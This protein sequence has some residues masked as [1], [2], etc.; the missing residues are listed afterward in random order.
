MDRTERFYRILNLLKGRR[1]VSRA[2]FLEMLEVSPATFKRD[3]EYLRDRL[4]APVVW[5]AELRGYRLAEHDGRFQLPGLWLD[6]KGLLALW[7]AETMLRELEPALIGETLGPMRT[8]MERLL[9]DLGVAPETFADRVRIVSAAHRPVDRRVFAVVLAALAAD[10][11]IEMRYHT[12]GRDT[13][14]TRTISPQRL[15]RYRDNWYLDAFC[16][17]R[18]GLR[19]FSVDAIAEAHATDLAAKRLSAETLDAH[20]QPGFGIFSGRD[21]DWARL[22]FSADSARWVAAESWHPQQKGTWL[23]GGAYL[24]EVPFTEPQELAMEIL[25]H[26]A[27]CEVL[28]PESLQSRVRDEVERLA[29]L[30]RIVPA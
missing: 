30:Y 10:V 6:R 27:G 12:R 16:H 2:E 5:D 24:L 21:V 9:N 26:G 28:A 22:R 25:K 29:K 7:V 13:D 11:R 15:V 18:G 17:T 4:E 8:Q 1:A 23:E 20:V 19:T 3:L 14:T